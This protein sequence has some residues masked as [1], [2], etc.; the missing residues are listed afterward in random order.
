MPVEVAPVPA[1][2]VPDPRQAAEDVEVVAQGV[3]DHQPGRVAPGEGGSL[4]STMRTASGWICS[5]ASSFTGAVICR[6]PPTAARR[7]GSAMTTL[8]SR[9]SGAAR[10]RR[11]HRRGCRQGR[12]HRP[13][14]R[15]RW[16]G[17]GAEAGEDHAAVPGEPLGVH[18]RDGHASYGQPGARIGPEPGGRGE[19]GG[20]VVVVE[21]D[22]A[23][24]PG[25][26]RLPGLVAAQL[27]PPGAGT[28]PVCCCVRVEAGEGRMSGMSRWVWMGWSPNLVRMC[29]CAG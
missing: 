26:H 24:Q 16:G 29:G 8:I 11:G 28:L 17:G 4:F 12:R 25:P 20:E 15:I 27:V 19:Q 22:D 13:T 21:V 9:G 10:G 6:R 23:C 18:A 7:T 2:V 3:N 14:Q 1:A 5:P